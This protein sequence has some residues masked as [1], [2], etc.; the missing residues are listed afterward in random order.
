MDFLIGFVLSLLVASV[1]FY[2]KSLSLSGYIAA[3]IVGTLIY[4]F[5]TY[6]IFSLL[7]AFFIFSS[8]ITKI[9]ASKEERKKGRNY[10]QVIINSAVALIFSF[11]YYISKNHLFLM[12]AAIGLAAAN[13]DTWA[14]EVGKLG[15]GKIISII[16]FKPIQKGESGGI[17]VLGTVFAVLGSLLISVLYFLLYNLYFKTSI[18]PF[19]T[20]S[21]ITI[22]G[23]LGC[24]IDSVLG[25]LLQ[26]KYLDIATGKIVES[27]RGIKTFKLVSGVA[28]INNDMVNLISTVSISLIFNLVLY[29]AVK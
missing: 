20:I 14:S 21:I 11:I 25:V 27:I 7:M 4:G 2:K 28:F 24:I 12:I 8:I 3:L 5:G 18:N 22:A 23:F 26:A 29:L 17:S 1:A 19:T 15:K 9:K 16:N 6:I 13:S 10:L